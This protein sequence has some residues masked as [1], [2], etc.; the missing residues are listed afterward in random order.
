LIVVD[1][2]VVLEA[3]VGFGRE[4]T[5]R[6]KLEAAGDLLAPSFL[7]VEVANVLRREV[8]L[9]NLSADRG[10]EALTDLIDLALTTYDVDY[11]LF[12]IWDFRANLTAYDAAYVALAE[13]LRVPLLTRDQKLA[14]TQGHGAQII[15]V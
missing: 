2:S 3:L 12:R 13:D 8:R 6:S 14:S 5:L 10:L 4:T 11:L 1:A 7:D 15:L 9:G